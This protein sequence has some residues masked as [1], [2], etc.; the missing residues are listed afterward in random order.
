MLVVKKFEEL[1]TKEIYAP[2]L[3]ACLEK[4]LWGYALYCLGDGDICGDPDKVRSI[5]W[6]KEL[7]DILKS[8]E[9]S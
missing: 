8:A 5:Y 1:I 3:A 4:I 2:D 7:L 6:S 9:N